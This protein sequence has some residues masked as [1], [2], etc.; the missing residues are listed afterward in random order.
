MTARDDGSKHGAAAGKH[1]PLE[2]QL[3][4]LFDSC[5]VTDKYDACNDG[6]RNGPTENFPDGGSFRNDGDGFF[7]GEFLIFFDDACNTAHMTCAND[8]DNLVPLCVLDF[9]CK[10]LVSFIDEHLLDFGV[11]FAELLH[12][13][14]EGVFLLDF[15][16]FFFADFG[17]VKNAREESA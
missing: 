10:E 13:G 7:A 14:V 3:S 5:K 15:L 2:A 17:L 1:H 4:G 6:E 9:T 16:E 12:H 11:G 8:S